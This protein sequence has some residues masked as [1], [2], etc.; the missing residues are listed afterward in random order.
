MPTEYELNLELDDVLALVLRDPSFSE[1]KDLR[2]SGLVIK[3]CV[4]IKTDKEGNLLKCS[5]DPVITKK[6]SP[7]DRLFQ[8]SDFIVIM[9]YSTWTATA[10]QEQKSALVHR[11]LMNIKVEK[12]TEGFTVSKRRF[13]LV[14]HSE[15]LKRFGAY[16]EELLTLRSYFALAAGRVITEVLADGAS[17]VKTA[18]EKTE[19]STEVSTE[20][21]AASSSPSDS[22]GS[23]PP[24]RRSVNKV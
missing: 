13:D 17:P 21:P 2:E 10:R 5:G 24:P 14:E 16:R 19:V 9:D 11:A 23:V 3:S 7:A 22:A 18:E 4:K 12:T 8:H 6:V 1:L 15:T 20:A